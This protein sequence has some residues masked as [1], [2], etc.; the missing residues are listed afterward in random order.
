MRSFKRTIS[1]LTNQ[2]LFHN[3]D[4]VVFLEGGSTS[5]NKVE[6]YS[7]NFNDDTNDIL[8]WSNIFLRFK[9][10]VRVKFKSV[11][12]K[13]TIKDIAVDIINGN[14]STVMVAMDNEF[15]EILEKRIQHNNILYTNG[16]SWENDV[17][18][19]G[20]IKEVIEELSA[21]EISTSDLNDN[22]SRFLKNI[23]IAVYSDGYLFSKGGSLFNRP[24]GHMSVINCEP[25]DL[26]HVKQNAVSLLITN[27]G[28]R[29]GTAYSFARRKL[30]DVEKH[31]YGHLFADYCFQVIMHYMRNR[32]QLPSLHKEIVYRMGINKFFRN[33]FDNTEIYNHYLNQ[34]QRI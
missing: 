6:V 7:G 11:G 10:G 26:P 16:Y 8:F 25:M 19:V 27:K 20:I 2:H 21:I 34:F 12:S 15:D 3:V 4:L 24:K 32:L 1:G 14:I 30:I 5:Y 9:N 13:T 17:W 22:F 18:S 28:V 33:H 23:K 31:C 29:K